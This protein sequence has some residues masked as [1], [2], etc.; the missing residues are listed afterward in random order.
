MKLSS[1]CRYALH[2]VF[3]LAFHAPKAPVGK[4]HFAQVKDIC[5][6]QGIPARFLEQVFQDL[7]RAGL[8]QSKRGP[9]GGHQL[10]KRPED[11]KL[12]DVIRAVDGP[13]ALT[14]EVPAASQASTGT[15]V[16]D[17]LLSEIAQAINACLDA[18][19]VADMCATAQTLELEA[20]AKAPYVYSI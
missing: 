8:V 4:R 6:R 7:R 10:A 20:Q 5:E 18:R 13:L 12:G 14:P 15:R 1:K 3:D 2:A 17:Q 19:T 16:T 9:R 11:I